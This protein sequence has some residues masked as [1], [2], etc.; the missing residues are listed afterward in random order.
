MVQNAITIVMSFLWVN[1]W[2]LFDL[3]EKTVLGGLRG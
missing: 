1:L 2:N 3:K